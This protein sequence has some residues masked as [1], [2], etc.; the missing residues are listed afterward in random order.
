MAIIKAINPGKKSLGR[1]INDL[2]NADEFG[3][4]TGKDCTAQSALDQMEV[5]KLIYDKTDKRQ[6]MHLCAVF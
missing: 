4:I 1:G 6:Y 3:L 5:T 2:T